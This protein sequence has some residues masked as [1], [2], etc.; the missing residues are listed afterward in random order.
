MDYGDPDTGA[1]PASRLVP[2]PP[3]GLDGHLG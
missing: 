2:G 3:S 1:C